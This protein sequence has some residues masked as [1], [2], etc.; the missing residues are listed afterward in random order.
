MPMIIGTARAVILVSSP[1]NNTKLWAASSRILAG[2][3]KVG[4]CLVKTLVFYRRRA[5]VQE[6][7]M[8]AMLW[9]AFDKTV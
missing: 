1:L 7:Q 9:R 6:V 2:A 3:P 4:K 5:F 8:G